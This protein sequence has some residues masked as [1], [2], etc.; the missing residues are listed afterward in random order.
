MLCFQCLCL[1]IKSLS[2]PTSLI[3]RNLSAIKREQAKTILTRARVVIG[4]SIVSTPWGIISKKEMEP[5]SVS[6]SRRMIFALISSR[7]AGSPVLIGAG[8]ACR[9]GCTHHTL[10]RGTIRSLRWRFSIGAL[11][12]SR[13][14]K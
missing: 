2:A 12:S 9:G 6:V 7:Q 11:A 1:N 4:S 5:I 13:C 3:I 8:N 10:I 14:S